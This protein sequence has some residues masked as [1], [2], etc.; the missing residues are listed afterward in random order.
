MN[1][2]LFFGQLKERIGCANTQVELEYPSSVAEVK[3]QL[4]QRG[5]LW[6]QLLAQG[7]VLSAVNQTMASDETDINAGDEIAFFPP[8][9]GG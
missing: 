9:T 7:N 6:Q 2:I 1:K 3:L 4:Q 8:V 5:E